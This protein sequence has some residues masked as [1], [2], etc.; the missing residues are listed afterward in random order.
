MKEG[1]KSLNTDCYEVGDLT[2]HLVNRTVFRDGQAIPLP[3]LSFDF[4]ATLIQSAPNAVDRE[5]LINQVWRSHFVNDDTIVQRVAMLRK[6]LGDDPKNPKY[7]RT[8]RGSGYALIASVKPSQMNNSSSAPSSDNT[9]A[10]QIAKFKKTQYWAISAL[11]LLAL[12]ATNWTHLFGDT[13][14]PSESSA[15]F[16]RE[17]KIV[18]QAQQLLSVWQAEETNKAIRILSPLIDANP[19]HAQALLTLSFALS[20]RETK[21]GGTLEDAQKAEK[22]ARQV[23]DDDPGLGRAWHALGYALDAQSRVEESL[24]AYQKAYEIDPTDTTARSSA[25]H[26]MFVRGRLYESLQQDL[27]GLS[28]LGSS[29]FAE[30]QVAKTLTLLGFENQND[31]WQTAKSLPLNDAQYLNERIQYHLSRNQLINA[32]QLIRDSLSSSNHNKQLYYFYA[33]LKLQAADTIKARE[34]YALAGNL[35]TKD[36]ASLDALSNN[37][38]SAQ[39]Q[40]TQLLQEILEGNTWPK[41]RITLAELYAATG[42][43]DKAIKSLSEAI[44]LGWRDSKVIETSPFLKDLMTSQQWQTLETRIQQELKAQ[45][46]LVTNSP[47]L[48]QLIQ[49]SL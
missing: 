7:V 14:T 28:S 15:L 45:K 19:P 34:Y 22:L 30:L 6:A 24:A 16:S 1:E 23:L 11:V 47:E 41:L 44:D 43:E 12:I 9:Q 48:L 20:T 10:Q 36:L 18:E 4:L 35:A 40:I 39:N 49:K 5:Q 27:T 25:A 33:R 3:E 42:Q 46:T 21:F 13:E 37:D 8:L 17:D 29:I 26:L 31:W 32:E 38:T 2:V